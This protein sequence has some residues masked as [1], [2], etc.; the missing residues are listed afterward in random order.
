MPDDLLARADAVLTAQPNPNGH[1]ERLTVVD[2]SPSAPLNVFKFQTAR[3]IGCESID[4]PEW[5]A[6]PW[7]ARKA[8]TE[9][10][11]KAKSAG[12]T[13]L[14]L[15]M[16]H[17]IVN[18][19]P[20]L[21]CPTIKGPVVY[22]SEQG[23]ASLAEA[24][25]RADLIECD[26]LHILTWQNTAGA[27]WDLSVLAAIA[28]AQEV[29]AVLLV[30]DTLPQ[31]AGMQ[32]DSE[33]DAGA[34]L[35]A[36]QPLQNA[37]ATGLAVLVLRHEKKGAAEVGE[38]G[39]GS[40]AFTGAVDIVLALRRGEGATKPTI[41]H[42][43]A[44]S[45]FDETPDLLVIEWTGDGYVSLGTETDVAKVEAERKLLI[46]A[47]TSEADAMSE[48]DLFAA[49][50]VKRTVAR[51][52]LEGYLKSGQIVRIGA[53][54]K[55]SPYLYWR[56]IHSDGAPREASESNQEALNLDADEERV[57]GDCGGSLGPD[58]KYQCEACER[59]EYDFWPDEG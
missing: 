54:K 17:A 6:R 42:L 18:G 46:V 23:Y 3:E 7:V 52:V 35:A 41:R 44:L 59:K 8:L 22:L 33:N 55:G 49:A 47:P 29:G 2:G 51:E 58:R 12:K 19:L 48:K 9:L 39:R 27:L 37:A 34:A 15:A 40:S 56:P 25:R 4:G 43:S 28:K 5:V 11:G 30:I 1:R 45:R 24:L 10:D 50:D 53:G 13:T 16:V 36:I 38:S 26:D 31:F 21:G 32:G 14:A 57:C 20:F